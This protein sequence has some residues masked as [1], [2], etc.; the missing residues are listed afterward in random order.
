MVVCNLR[1]GI[2]ERH[3][4][5]A[6]RVIIWQEFGG[7]DQVGR[8]SVQCENRVRNRPSRGMTPL[9]CSAWDAPATRPESPTPNRSPERSALNIQLPHVSAK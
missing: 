6:L 7:F 2:V 9:G 8:D 3:D 4:D 5:D 1:D